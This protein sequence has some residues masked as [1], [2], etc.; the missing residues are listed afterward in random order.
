MPFSIVRNDITKMT[1]DAI[2]N[3]ANSSLAPGGGVCGAIFA[4]AGY[5]QMDRACRAIGHCEAGQAV[6]TPG[7]ALPA[8]YVI[9]AVG[10]VWHGGE[11]G[12]PALLR[13]C[14]R[15]ALALAKEKRC[16]SIAFPLISSGIYGYPKGEALAV[17]VEAIRSYLEREEMEIVL[18]VFDKA[19]VDI[20]QERFARLTAYIDDHY[21]ETHAL[22]RQPTEASFIRRQ[23]EEQ[24]DK[25]PFLPPPPMSA[26][27]PMAAPAA[28]DSAPKRKR[29]TLAELLDRLDESFSRMLLRLIDQ[30]GLTDT[31]V[32]KRANIDRKLFSKLRQ[33]S[34]H[35]S[36][37]TA[38]ALAIALELNLDE[39]KDLLGRAGY[40]LSPSNKSDV[41]VMY[42]IE[43]GSYDIYEI[44]EALFAFDQRLLGA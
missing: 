7:F 29:R 15:S 12:E 42:F 13:S 1:T 22:H 27:M 23:E 26:Q 41:I 43:T 37:A 3:A 6:V 14:Y 25:A 34:Y 35:P 30:R 28:A 18:V 4:A 32:Y 38:I 20:G 5:Q 39:T 2:V 11:Q 44:N 19:A 36:K 17:A 40:A 24:A 10:P 8:K 21:V 31:A 33:D 9:H 16:R